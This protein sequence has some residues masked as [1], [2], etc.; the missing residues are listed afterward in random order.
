MIRFIY[1]TLIVS[2]ACLFF[3]I[4][5]EVLATRVDKNSI[6]QATE[7]CNHICSHKCDIP[8]GEPNVSNKAILQ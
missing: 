3:Y 7:I 2:L 1:T 4:F 6:E 5:G 8:K